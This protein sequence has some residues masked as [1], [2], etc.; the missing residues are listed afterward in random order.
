MINLI[1]AGAFDGF[2]DRESLMR[3]YVSEISDTKKRITLQNMKML[4]DF[5]LIPDEYDMER[6]VYNFNKYIKKLK[7]DDTYFGLDEIAFKDESSISIN[8]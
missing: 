5:G 3:Y 2:G 1:K 4:I 7:L 6:R 8:I